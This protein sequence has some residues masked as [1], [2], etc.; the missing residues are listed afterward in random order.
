[1]SSSFLEVLAFPEFEIRSPLQKGGGTRMKILEWFAASAALVATSKA[2]EGTAVRH[3]VHAWIEDD[4]DKMSDA[5]L[6]LLGD[7]RRAEE[8]AAHG[9]EFVKDLDWRAIAQRHLA[10]AGIWVEHGDTATAA[11]E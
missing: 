6:M 3:G 9:R 11:A 8:L 4:F 5:V 10:L 2:V 1:L 7:R